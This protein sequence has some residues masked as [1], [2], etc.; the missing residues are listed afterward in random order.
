MSTVAVVTDDDKISQFA[1]QFGDNLL[2]L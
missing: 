2:I 1:T